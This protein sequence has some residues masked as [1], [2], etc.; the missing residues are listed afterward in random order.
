MHRRLSTDN[1]AAGASFS[2]RIGHRNVGGEFYAKWKQLEPETHS[3]FSDGL[4]NVQDLIF[5]NR[6]AASRTIRQNPLFRSCSDS[7]YA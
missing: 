4:L 1:Y 6:Q 2:S 3:L 5:Q 7:N